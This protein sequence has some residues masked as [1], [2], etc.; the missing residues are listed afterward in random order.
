[1]VPFAL[2]EANSASGAGFQ[3]Q[4]TSKSIFQRR[5]ARLNKAIFWVLAKQGS[6]TVYEIWLELR[7][8]R[9]FSYIRYHIVNRRVRALEELGYIEKSGER[10][11]KTGFA[12]KLYQLT[13][14]AY[15]VLLLDRTNL[16]EFVE[17]A[18]YDSIVTAISAVILACQNLS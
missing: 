2:M 15:L 12:G 14:R 6:L 11:T 1:M 13:V 4:F 16:D 3:H 8:L 5:E 7:A 9:D 18:S 17:E 10:R